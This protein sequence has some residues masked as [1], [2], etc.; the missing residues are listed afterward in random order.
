[1][2]PFK[3]SLHAVEE[4][5]ARDPADLT[6]LFRLG[7]AHFWVGH[8]HWENNDLAAADESM[9]HY[10]RISEK[11]YKAEPENDDYILELGFAFNNL[12]ILSDRRG[13]I[14]A[15]LGYNQRMIDLSREVYERDKNNE[16][17]LRALADAYSWSGSILRSDS[18]LSASVEQF[19]EYL[20]LATEAG[21]RDPADTQWIEN[22]MLAH[23][24]VADGM[25]ELGQVDSASSNFKEGMSLAQQLI[26]I[27]AANKMWQVEFAM[28]AQRLAQTDIRAGKINRGLDTLEATRLRVRE[29]LSDSPDRDDL[30]WIDAELNLLGGELLLGLGDIAG[31]ASKADAVVVVARR[32]SEEDP[33]S[34]LNRTLLIKSLIFE[35]RIATADSESPQEHPNWREVLTMIDKTE[36][37]RFY[38]EAL[39][40]YVR[41]SLYAGRRNNIENKI[42]VLRDAGYQHPE[43]VTMLHEYG[44]NY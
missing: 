33:S 29:W 37:D 32:L 2:V 15:A 24:F 44:I 4:L 42:K 11:L 40:A 10:F 34:I 23:R 25:L 38:P 36:K 39:N 35:A 14:K 30:L 18:Q 22:R 21:L 27:E 16:T 12:A 43:F 3:E 5:S 28:L 7:Q 8:I 6:R 13:D 41:A 17:Y 20:K 19:A 26:E 1:M 31:A 9:Q